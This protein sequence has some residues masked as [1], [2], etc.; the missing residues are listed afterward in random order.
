[1]ALITERILPLPRVARQALIKTYCPPYLRPAASASP[2]DR[3]CLARPYLGRR[4]RAD[5]PFPPN[6]TLR[7]FNLCLDQIFELSLPAAS[8]AATMGEA[9]GVTH[10]SANVMGLD[11]DQQLWDIFSTS[12]VDKGTR[13]LSAPG[14]D[15]RLIDLPRNFIE[16]CVQRERE[17]EPGSDVLTM[18]CCTS[19]CRNIE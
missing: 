17:G 1:M 4:R 5:A 15:K 16:A 8:A 9:L 18:L 14:K 10:W 12:N 6:F 11:L 13:V 7:N 2:T 3:D 19:F